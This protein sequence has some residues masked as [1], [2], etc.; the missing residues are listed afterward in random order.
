MASAKLRVMYRSHNI[1]AATVDQQREAV[2]QYLMCNTMQHM[3]ESSTNSNEIIQ[4]INLPS[5]T[6]CAAENGCIKLVK[7]CVKLGVDNYNEMMTHAASYGHVEF[8]KLCRKWRG[9]K[10]T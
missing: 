1:D 9:K 4:K 10:L 5:V 8:A 2:C 7:L 3:C 6:I